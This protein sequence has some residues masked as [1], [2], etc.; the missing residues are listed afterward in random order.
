M[1]TS[2]LLRMWHDATDGKIL[3]QEARDIK[4]MIYIAE[5]ID[6]DAIPNTNDVLAYLARRVESLV[7]YQ[8]IDWE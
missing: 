8:D 7:Q 5:L 2:Q 6:G 3:T 4:A 1:T